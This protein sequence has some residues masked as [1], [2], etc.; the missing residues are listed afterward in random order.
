MGH[1]TMKQS[2]FLKDCVQSGVH[3]ITNV[4][5]AAPT[6]KNTTDLITLK[7]SFLPSAQQ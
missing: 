3:P 2:R 7:M 5:L 1:A 6:H 4:K